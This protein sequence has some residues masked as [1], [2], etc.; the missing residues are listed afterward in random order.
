MARLFPPSDIQTHSQRL[1]N[2]ICR[3][4]SPVQMAEVSS[5]LR[6]FAV[7]E[8]I[9]FIAML[10]GHPKILARPAG[11]RPAWLFSRRKALL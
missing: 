6:N 9:G 3:L 4:A 7:A 10:D 2:E 1:R 11:K 5:H 8:V